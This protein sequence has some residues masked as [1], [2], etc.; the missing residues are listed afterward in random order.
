[1]GAE[2]GDV[3][4]PLDSLL[5]DAAFG[6]LRRFNPGMSGLRLGA[7]LASRPRTV[8][9][10]AAS[11]ARDLAKVA[12][13]TSAVAPA[14]K[15]RR[16]AD[17]AWT[18]NPVFHRLV[19]GYL[20][21]GQAAEDLVTD[22]AMGWP[23]HER[24]EFVALN[25]VEALS[26]SNNPVLN[27]VAL[28][29][30][31][32]SGGSSFVRGAKNFVQDM[33][34]KPRVPSMVDTTA[35]EV[36]KNLGVTPGSV[37]LR[38]DLFELIQYQPQTET[39]HGYPMLMVPPTI[40][41]Y[42]IADLAPGRSMVEHFVK[43]GQQVFMM[44][45]RNPDRDDAEWGM[46]TYINA[47]LEAMDAVEEICAT[48]K[49]ILFSLCAGGIISSMVLGHLLD[50]GQEHRLAAFAL[51]VTLLDQS[52]AGL[53]S[54]MMSP[55][56]V[57]AATRKSRH[58]GFLDGRA[59]AEI[60]AWLRPQDLVWNYWVNNYLLGKQPPAFDVLYWNADTTRMTAQLHSDFMHMGLD[61]ALTH[62]G[63]ATALGSPVDL[64][65]TTV[66]SYV[67]AGI[68][69]HICP[70]TS[71]YRSV[72][73]I[74]GHSRFVLSTNGHIAAL[75]NPPGN[76][77]SSF[78]VAD[79]PPEDPQ[80]LLATVEKTSGSWWNDFVQW[81]TA[82]SGPDIPAPKTLGNSTYK[83]LAPAPGTYVFAK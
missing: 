81:L 59:L 80:E 35:F 36:G 39:V 12:I 50:T 2:N 57:A 61:N 51:G 40:N 66:D 82:H 32:E 72:Q 65:R 27:P 29:T 69:D 21:A 6:P 54:A 28:K 62:P 47:V 23:D 3:A 75:V 1:M 52:R 48:K 67:I 49:S 22:A 5:V 42:Y 30:A 38:T 17:K 53:M 33:S 71:C 11:T 64:S 31:L 7:R 13:G 26:P 60:F 37:V 25:L 46:D 58:D 56:L 4:A 44:T 18:D 19:Q 70:W 16:F 14:P 45:W 9:R 20:V 77:K 34:V 74:G 41:K 63:M 15:D 55:E 10:R 83:V 76:P 79:D 43:S 73:M 24:L 68:A 8:A 78:R